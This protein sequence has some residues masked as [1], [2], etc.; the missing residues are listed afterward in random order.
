MSEQP[1]IPGRARTIFRLLSVLTLIEAVL[2][3][4]LTA[5]DRLVVKGFDTRLLLAG[6]EADLPEF[7]ASVSSASRSRIH[8]EGFLPPERLPERDAGHHDIGAGSSVAV[9][10]ARCDRSKTTACSLEHQRD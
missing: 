6:R 4:L 9:N 5:F 3:L 10:L 2:G 1:S 7:L 8:Y